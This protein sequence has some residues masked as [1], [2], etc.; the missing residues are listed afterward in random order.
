M[1][2]RLARQARVV[3]EAAGWERS[4]LLAWILVWAGL[5]AAFSFEDGASA[6]C[7]LRIAELA[8]AGLG[9]ELCRPAQTSV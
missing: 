3:A 1:P 7:A 2:G 9:V 4:R 8:A 5:S 6:G